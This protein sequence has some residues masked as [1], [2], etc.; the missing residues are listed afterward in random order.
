MAIVTNMHCLRKGLV[1][2]LLL[3]LPW[4]GMLAF[5]QI[6][7]ACPMEQMDGPKH[8]PMKCCDAGMP[9][10]EQP[11]HCL[12][13]NAGTSLFT[14]DLEFGGTRAHISPAVTL[15]SLRTGHDPTGLWRPPRI[16]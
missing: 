11:E 2:L 5:A 10:C 8:A 13:C 9:H 3:V 1:G 4:T 6:A 16:S 7:P 15:T 12:H 14:L